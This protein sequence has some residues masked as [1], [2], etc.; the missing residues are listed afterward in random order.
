MARSPKT[1][2]EHIVSLYGHITGLKKDI[3]VLKNNHLRHMHNDIEAIDKKLDHR[4]DT[5]TNWI[6]CGLGAVVLVVATQ[7][8]YF[9]SN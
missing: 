8:L 2:G 6:I 3:S 5:I 4:F 9:L 1:T 7:L